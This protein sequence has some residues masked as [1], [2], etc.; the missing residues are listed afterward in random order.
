MIIATR[1][2][3]GPVEWPLA[4]LS[5][6]ADC[7]LGG[8]IGRFGGKFPGLLL[9]RLSAALAWGLSAAAALGQ[10]GEFDAAARRALVCLGQAL[11]GIFIAVFS[12]RMLWIDGV[13]LNINCFSLSAM[14][15][16]S[17]ALGNLL[18]RLSGRRHDAMP[19]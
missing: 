18:L 14:L 15:L 8:S 1:F 9:L 2:A 11:L 13:A 16:M 7:N 4:P 5:N 12:D 6:P 10:P 3:V 17:A 19:A